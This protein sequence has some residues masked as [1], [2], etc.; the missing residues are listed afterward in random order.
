MPLCWEEKYERQVDYLLVWLALLGYSI[1]AS[2][3]G[4]GASKNMASAICLVKRPARPGA[5]QCIFDTSRYVLA[6]T[7]S[8]G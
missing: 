4:T 2:T 3:P 7:S 1:L 8:P 5:T 6:M